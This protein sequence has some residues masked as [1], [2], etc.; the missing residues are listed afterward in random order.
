MEA[1]DFDQIPQWFIGA[2]L[3]YAENLLFAHGGN[4]DDGDKVAV[5]EAS[6]LTCDL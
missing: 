6:N 3:N 5:I 4:L 2:E 1:K